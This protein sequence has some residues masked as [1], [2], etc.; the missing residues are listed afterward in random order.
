MEP[1]GFLGEFLL[2]ALLLIIGV[3]LS[4]IAEL[5]RRLLKEVKGLRAEN[6]E[7]F[8]RTS[9]LQRILLGEEDVD[10]WGGVK[11]VTYENREMIHELQDIVDGLT[12]F[13]DRCK[14]RLETIQN[15]L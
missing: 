10:E 14:R 9:R 15:K 2:Q 12:Q 5:L 7:L 8:K 11:D 4:V 6:K 13:R 1:A 3:I